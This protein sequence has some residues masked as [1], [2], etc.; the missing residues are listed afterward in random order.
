MAE[1]EADA[2]KYKE[3]EKA[4]VLAPA[5]SAE[6]VKAANGGTADGEQ[7]G[8]G[9]AKSHEEMNGDK[10]AGVEVGAITV[11]AVVGLP[12][13]P[14]S[15]LC[16]PA[17]PL[18]LPRGSPLPPPPLPTRDTTCWPPSLST[19]QSQSPSSLFSSQYLAAIGAVATRRRPN[20]RS[21]ALWSASSSPPWSRRMWPRSRRRS[22]V[23][24]NYW[25]SRWVFGISNRAFPAVSLL[26]LRPG[27]VSPWPYPGSPCSH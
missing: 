9:E 10:K 24:C 6:E 26:D 25:W 12:T 15:S 20:R 22:P 1:K 3:K 8:N 21:P 2:D 4:Q 13:P 16:L 7:A 18:P 27:G 17:R 14:Q 5:P 11:V 19:S 23:V